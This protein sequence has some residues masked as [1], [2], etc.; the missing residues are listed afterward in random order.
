MD[1]TGA[2][3]FF[4]LIGVSFCFGYILASN[5]ALRGGRDPRSSRKLKTKVGSD[6]DSSSSRSDSLKDFMA[7]SDIL[8]RHGLGNDKLYPDFD[9]SD[10]EDDE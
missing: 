2:F 1:Y 8:T 9:P 4:I 3:I 7:L 5:R 6:A 10:F